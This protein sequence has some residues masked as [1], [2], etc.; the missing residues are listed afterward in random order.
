MAKIATS[1]TKNG[2]VGNVKVRL[3]ALPLTILVIFL[4]LVFHL[5]VLSLFDGRVALLFLKFML[6]V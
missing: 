1:L 5:C 6:Q 4:I 2:F 3:F